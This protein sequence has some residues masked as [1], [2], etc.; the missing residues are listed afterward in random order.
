M[1]SKLTLICID[2]TIAV[3]MAPLILMAGHSFVKRLASDRRAHHSSDLTFSL[4]GYSGAN[5]GSLRAEII[6]FSWDLQPSHVIG[7]LDI[8]T[9]DLADRTRSVDPVAPLLHS[10]RKSLSYLM[11]L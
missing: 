10:P 4:K 1:Q 2:T 9:N 3:N 7:L 5:V 6:P 8:G 11:T